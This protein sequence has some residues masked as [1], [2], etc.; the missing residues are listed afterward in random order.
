[1]SENI[2]LIGGGGHAD[3]VES[4]AGKPVIFRAADSQYLGGKVTVDI[5]DPGDNI[6][7]PVHIAVGAPAVRKELESK[8]PGDVYETIVSDHA[9]VDES[10]EIGEGSLVAPSAVIT[11]NVKLGAHV[12]V[13]V[14]ASVQHNTTVG[15]FST[16]SPGV[17]IGGDV[18]IGEGVFIGIGANVSNSVK[19]ANG[20]VVGA[21]ATILEN[22]DVENGVYVGTPARIVKQ[23]EGWLREI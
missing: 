1:V 5:S 7:T 18:E 4:Y 10:V 3:E 13:N 11:T 12:I 20:V 21:G 14:A 15:D 9:M 17:N 19:I 23:N 16:I 6:N 8:W 2:G 22:A